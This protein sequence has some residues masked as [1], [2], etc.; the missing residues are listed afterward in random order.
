MNLS[1]NERH[2]SPL[3]EILTL[4]EAS[5]LCGISAHTLAQQAEKGKLRA[6]KMGHTWLTTKEWLN[7][8]VARYARRKHRNSPPS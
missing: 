7:D 8:Y 4:A 2:S 6:R 1:E 3:D 5:S